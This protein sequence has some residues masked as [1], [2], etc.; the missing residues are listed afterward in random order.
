MSNMSSLRWDNATFDEYIEGQKVRALANGRTL[1]E[2]I[3]CTLRRFRPTVNAAR[4]E[5]TKIANYMAKS[6]H[7][8]PSLV[9]RHENAEAH[10]HRLRVFVTQLKEII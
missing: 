5:M 9:A 6:D 3:T 1:R 8:S 10:Y 2:Q 4:G 7:P